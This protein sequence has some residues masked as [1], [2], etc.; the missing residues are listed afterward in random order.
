[1]TKSTSKQPSTRYSRMKRQLPLHLMLLPGIIIVIM[2]SYYPL[3]GLVMAFQRFNPR[4]GYWRSPFVGLDHFRFMFSMPA[5]RQVLFN[6]VFISFMKMVAML[7]VPIFFALLLDLVRSSTYKRVIQTAIYFPFFLSWVILGGILTDILSPT[8]G[9]VG[10]F[11]QWLGFEPVFWLGEPVLFPYVLVVTD[12][13]RNFGYGT[14]IYLAAISSID[15]SQYEAAA[16][17]GANRF[18]QTMRI[19]LPSMGP[20]IILM[21]TLSLGNILNAGFDQVLN[22]YNPIVRETGDIIDT[23]VYRVGLVQVNFE[24]ATAMGMFRSLVSLVFIATGYY[25]ARRFANYTVF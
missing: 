7:I 5:F 19:T 11:T 21:A 16:I 1:M 8:T 9:I 13:W 25:L 15:S 22:L 12:V 6:T 17:D 2:F 4:L 10:M 23:M 24:M 20:I 3:T 18:Q 14:I